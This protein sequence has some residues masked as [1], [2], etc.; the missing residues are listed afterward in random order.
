M[1]GRDQTGED[2]LER[3]AEDRDPRSNAGTRRL[4]RPFSGIVKRARLRIEADRSER[5]VEKD[6]Y[7]PGLAMDLATNHGWT[8]GRNDDSVSVDLSG[9][10]ASARDKL[11]KRLKG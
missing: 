10:A 2:L 6:R 4:P 1:G 11:A 7:T 5:L 9:E 3:N 8:T